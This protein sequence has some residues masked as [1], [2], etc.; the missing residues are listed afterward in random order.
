M[1]QKKYSNDKIEILF[2]LPVWEVATENCLCENQVSTRSTKLCSTSQLEICLLLDLFMLLFVLLFTKI[3]HL[4][5]L[6]G[7]LNCAQRV[8][9]KKNLS[10]VNIDVFIVI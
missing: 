9:Q 8:S 3:F 10:N 2:A 7:A 1:S 5:H 6:L 4:T